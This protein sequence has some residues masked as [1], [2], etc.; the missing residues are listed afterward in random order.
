MHHPLAQN[1]WA[2]PPLPHMK[3]LFITTSY[4]CVSQPHSAIFVRRHAQAVATAGI[5]VHVLHCQAAERMAVPWHLVPEHDDA[6]TEGFPTARLLFRPSRLRGVSFARYL[7]GTIAAIRTI[8]QS[9]KPDLVHAHFYAAAIPASVPGHGGR[10][11]VVLTEH[12]SALRGTLSRREATKARFAYAR[13]SKVLPVSRQLGE[14]L[15]AR[16]LT[17][18]YQVVPNTV[19][20][21]VF[22]P[23]TSQNRSGPLRLL[24]VG[25]L[26]RGKGLSH[27]LGA[28]SLVRGRLDWS[29]VVAGDGP[30]KDA[31]VS[32][33]HYL[34]ID[35]CVQFLGQKHPSEIPRL[36]AGADLLA[37]PSLVENCSCAALEGLASGL[38][39]L[40]SPAVSELVGPEDGVIAQTTEPEQLAGALLEL[41]KRRARFHP[42]EIAARAQAYSLE[43][44]G[45]VLAGVY[46]EVVTERR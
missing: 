22:H 5:Q 17:K 45:R 10:L 6:V 27:L 34:G 9:F 13:A 16:N 46:E 33:A 8:R 28:L 2:L 4:P 3:A 37:V 39:I 40:G 30:D 19:D 26:V 20:T 29:L 12:S 35:A 18:A 38:P 31:L 36:M 7:F 11:P 23:E 1:R 15:V 14:A 32:Q 25:R 43:S 21:S 42:T 24:H 41:A 44:I